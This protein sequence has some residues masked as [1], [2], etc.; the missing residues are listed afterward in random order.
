M[1]LQRFEVKY[2]VSELQA[3]AI[4]DYILPYVSVDAHVRQGSHY[5]INSLYYD[6]PSLMLY[7][8]S[9]TGVKNRFK[10]RVRA[11]G[12]A[13]GQPAF[14]EIKRRIDGAVRKSRGKLSGVQVQDFLHGISD[15]GLWDG[16]GAR[17]AEALHRFRD[18]MDRVCAAPKVYVRYMREAYVGREEGGVR[19]TFDREIHTAPY[20]GPGGNLWVGNGGWRPL[21]V[22]D[23]VLEVKFNGAFPHWI[24]DMIRRFD[25]LRCSMSKYVAGVDILRREGLCVPL[26]GRGMP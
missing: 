12:D 8:D 3:T 4:R 16:I 20:D 2:R 24:L 10:L 1:N 11:Y 26:A 7:R 5:P 18:L 13:P 15:G 25:L 21:A 19:V 9:A 6:S 22:S 17:D 23:V 14:F